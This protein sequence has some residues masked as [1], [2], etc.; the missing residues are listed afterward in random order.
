LLSRG[1]SR[2]GRT[3]LDRTPAVLNGILALPLRLEAAAIA[4]GAH[5]PAGTSLGLLCRKVDRS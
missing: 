1:S 2:Q 4:R 3:D 5:L